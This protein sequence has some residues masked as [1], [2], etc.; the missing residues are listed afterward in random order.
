MATASDFK[1]KKGL[2]V[3]GG[4]LNLGNAQ[5]AVIQV[6]P[7]AGTNAVGKNL[8]ISSG[9]GTGSG[10]SGSIQLA[11]AAISQNGSTAVNTTLTSHLV[12]SSAGI[13]TLTAGGNLD[14]G[15]HNLRANSLTAD[16]LAVGNVVFTG[17]NGLLTTDSDMTFVTDTL[18][19]TKLG[20]FEATGAINFDSENMTNVDI[21]SGT[22]DGSTIATSNITV[23]SGKTLDV[24][25]GTL[26][27]ATDQISG[28]AVEGGTIAAT[29]ITGLTTA[30]ITA[31]A[32]IDIGTYDLRAATITADTM[33]A[34]GVAFYGTAG[35]LAYDSDI[36]F[37]TET[38]TVTKLGAFEAT[39][40]IDFSDENMTNVDIDSGAIDG[41]IIG[42]S[43]TAAGSFG[44]IVGTTITGSN[45]LSIDSTTESTSTVTG[46][47]HTDGG[48]GVAKD[49][50]FGNDLSLKSESA[51]LTMGADDDV[52]LRHI[53]DEG[54]QIMPYPTTVAG[55]TALEIKSS[56]DDVDSSKLRFTKDR[57][58]NTADNDAIG[59]ILF[60]SDDDANNMT[61]YGTIRSVV[62]DATNADE[63]GA[64]QMRPIVPT[65]AGAVGIIDGLTVA[66]RTNINDGIVVSVGGNNFGN[67]YTTQYGQSRV[68][69]STISLF[70]WEATDGDRHGQ[71]NTAAG[72][73]SNS[74]ATTVPAINIGGGII[75]HTFSAVGQGST[76]GD[77]I[78]NLYINGSGY[79]EGRITTLSA[80]TDGSA[81]LG[82][83]AAMVIETV[84]DANFGGYYLTRDRGN[85]TTYSWTNVNS[86]GES[87]QDAT[88]AMGW[89]TGGTDLVFGHR[90][91][92]YD[93]CAISANNP[94]TNTQALNIM[95]LTT[96]GHMTLRKSQAQLRLTGTSNPYYTALRA[97]G[98]IDSNDIY[99][100]PTDFPTTSG[101]VLKSTDA[102]IM[103][104]A[105][106]SSGGTAD[107]VL[108]DDIDAGN[109]QVDIETT[110]AHTINIGASTS[111]ST[112][113]SDINIAT[114]GTRTL[115]LGK[116]DTTLDINSATT[117]HDAATSH[118][119][120]APV[121]AVA[122][123]T[124][125][126]ITSPLTAITATTSVTATTPLF[127][128]ESSA[129]SK[130]VLQIKNT[131]DG[132]TAGELKFVSDDGA[133]GADGDD[134]G[135]ISFYAD[136]S[137]QEQTVFASIVA[138]VS[139]SLD[140]DEAG[141]LSF[142]VSE[143]NGT[144][145]QL[146]A[147]LILEGEHA[148]DGQV[149]VTIGAGAASTTT[150]AGDLTVN[151]ATTTISTAQ[152]TVEDSLITVAKGNDTLANAGGA[153][154][155]IEATGGTNPSFTYQHTPTAWESNIDMNLASG[156][157]YKI[158][159]VS[160][161][162][163]TT[164]NSSVETS[165]LTEVG[166]LNAGSITSGFGS[167]DV[168]TDAITTTGLISGGSL[169]IDHVL[170]NGTVSSR[171]EVEHGHSSGRSK[172]TRFV[173]V[174]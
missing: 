30:G 100:L 83:G 16:G 164:L 90:A 41:T 155:E 7:V 72:G 73:G 140:T 135:T 108:A 42:A 120:T 37:A 101:Y 92:G 153:G 14:I 48:L 168:G 127:S 2:Q 52:H 154:I 133:A 74:L 138:E 78:S 132:T 139:E 8:V 20:A 149:D 9:E 5:H 58:T 91:Q 59:K 69:G 64:I 75:P 85:N 87:L 3:A 171:N 82:L 86:G 156:K 97:S 161:L 157:S 123:T 84:D 96:T 45:I 147:G 12:V 81:H 146:T 67:T 44:A 34:G 56:A 134:I 172:V 126:T 165:G 18:T 23:G 27:L 33:T 49:A 130:P 31:S 29:T 145:A 50:H 40:A 111:G 68:G 95:N 159:D 22:I 106:E 4:D 174:H 136:N 107:S 57:G 65:A 76:A 128:I 26:T 162:T 39:G 32:N 19:V 93:D 24:S 116:A 152:L 70:Q 47:I 61:H 144:T 10:A 137:A 62:A 118:T 129:T 11:T 89:Q 113:T 125:H 104:W 151:G 169:D 98:S 1:V 71:T 167:I 131:H 63:V 150:I 53:P 36:T 6:D 110:D 163:A 15:A 122:A 112:D 166:A 35:L 46:S 51:L 143:S 25:G 43:A 80:T 66:G 21:D 102:G 121:S 105:A 160:I 28:N 79:S 141:K 54:I 60:Y 38:L 124:S 103:S 109:A 55:N 148:T 170:I 13:T 88:W 142:F 119:L 99:T 77:Y 114:G 117:T 94:L 115:T 173:R 158:N 17:A